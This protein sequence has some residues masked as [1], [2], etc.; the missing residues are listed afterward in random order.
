MTHG[1]AARILPRGM[2]G[3]PRKNGRA[4]DVILR[5]H[6]SRRVAAE[7][8]PGLNRGRSS[9]VSVTGTFR[10]TLRLPGTPPAVDPF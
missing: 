3:P 10:R 6:D 8:I 4:E 7:I 9:T 5:H 2:A 1:R